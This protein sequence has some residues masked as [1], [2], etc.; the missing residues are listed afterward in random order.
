VVGRI[1]LAQNRLYEQSESF[2]NLSSL[3]QS[4]VVHLVRHS[5]YWIKRENIRLLP[6][7]ISRSLAGVR[8]THAGQVL[9]E[10]PDK[11]PGPPCRGLGVELKF[12]PLKKS[13]VSKPRL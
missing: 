1:Q 9:G 6:Y 4:Y 11:H 2:V 13:T 12:S 3:Q 10:V 8:A 7:R 5:I